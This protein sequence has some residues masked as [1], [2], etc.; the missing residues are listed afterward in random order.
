MCASIRPSPALLVASIVLGLAGLSSGEMFGVNLCSF[1]S[2]HFFFF[3]NF[4]G[5]ETIRFSPVS[6]SITLQLFSITG[7]QEL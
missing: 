4:K 3:L 7:K 5:K 2:P 1:F 6:L